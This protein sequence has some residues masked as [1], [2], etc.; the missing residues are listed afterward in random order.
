M[1]TLWTAPDSLRRHLTIRLVL[2]VTVLSLVVSAIAFYGSRQIVHSLS[3]SLITQT[4]NHIEARLSQFF[5]PV[6]HTLQ[7]ARSWG[8]GGHLDHAHPDALAKLFQPVISEYP[9]ISAALIADSK[10]QEFMLLQR[11]DRWVNRITRH[12]EWSGRSQWGEWTGDRPDTLQYEWR[13]LDYDPRQRPWFQ[14]ATSRYKQMQTVPD[15]FTSAEGIHWTPPYTFFTTQEPGITAA[16]VYEDTGSVTRVIGLDILLS[17]ISKFTTSLSISSNGMV[18]VLTEDNRLVGLPRYG[19][20]TDPATWR[21]ALLKH[22]E[23]L[24]L[25][26]AS[27]AGHAFD[28]RP[29]GDTTP[30]RFTSDGEVWWAQ[31]RA[32]ALTKD[33]HLNIAVLIPESDLLTDVSVMITVIIGVTLVVLALS[34][35]RVNA[36]AK[37]LS[38]PI[39]ALVKQ[40]ERISQGDLY[41]TTP[42]ASSIEEVR[43]LADAH[44]TM[45]QGLQSLMKLERDLQLARQIQQDTFPRTLPNVPGYTLAAWSDPA[46]ATA[47]DT[48][49]LIGIRAASDGEGFNLVTDEVDRAAF[50]LADATGHGVGPALSVTQVRAMLRMA[51]RLGAPLHDIAVHLNEQLGTDLSEGRFITAWLGILDRPSHQL[52]CF[53]AGQAPLFHYRAQSH[54]IDVLAADAPPFGVNPTLSGAIPVQIALEVGD[55]FLVISDGIIETRNGDG[56]VYGQE[57]IKMLLMEHRDLSAQDWMALLVAELLRFS[58]QKHALDDRTAVV[59]KRL[60]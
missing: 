27:D 42:I 52:L 47:G 48:Y 26:L 24:N 33:A 36:F 57:R 56:Q 54:S 7:I 46:D 40:S 31:G 11:P 34:L 25:A 30:I 37:R 23:E 17:D 2:V 13:Q 41:P 3:R 55:I 53:S 19:P 59:L 58:Q 15:L 20:F 43:R 8:K 49:D 22:P 4:L 6:I 5:A 60:R 16:V 1:A 29:V 14:G 18:T 39:E 9:H 44:E 51:V 45:R 50:L 38:R 21:N 12:E 10:G 28:A 35:L 32:F